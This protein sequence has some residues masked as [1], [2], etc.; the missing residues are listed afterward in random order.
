VVDRLVEEHAEVVCVA[1]K[2]RL[3]LLRVMGGGGVKG[4]TSFSFAFKTAFFCALRCQRRGGGS[5]SMGGSCS[6]GRFEK[7]A[8]KKRPCTSGT[9]PASSLKGHLVV[10][11]A[12]M[13]G[14]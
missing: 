10:V 11:G 12:V 4:P 1:E 2:P 3:Q 14:L 13:T 9:P 7:S 6:D 8:A 5:Y